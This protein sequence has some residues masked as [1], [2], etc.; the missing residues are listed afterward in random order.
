MEANAFDERL[1]PRAEAILELLSRPR[2]RPGSRAPRDPEVRKSLDRLYTATMD[3]RRLHREGRLAGEQAAVALELLDRDP[4]GLGADALGQLLETVDGLLVSAGDDIH[5]C[6]LLETEYERDRLEG[7]G[8]VPTWGTL[9][10]GDRLAASKA[11]A[12]G[13]PVSAEA[14]EE[15]RNRLA[16]L[17]RARHSLYALGRARNAARAARLLR[18]APVVTALV[19]VLIAVVDV[20]AEDVSWRRGL[21]VALAGALGATVAGAYKLRDQLPRLSDLR[22]FWSAFALQPP[23]GAAAGVVVWIVLLS[24]LLGVADVGPD[25]AVEAAVAFAAGFSEPF[26]LRTVERIAGP[27]PRKRDDG[28]R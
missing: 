18:L 4:S 17:L 10:G 1:R 2:L 23:L 5:L 16:T 24:G 13:Q 22:L 21:L 25:W 11:F 8:P 6:A 9:Y 19:V 3:A 7:G 26:L 12:A 28:S 14:L 15:A 20:V 27:Q